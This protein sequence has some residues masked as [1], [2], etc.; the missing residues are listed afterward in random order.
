MEGTP[1]QAILLIR[2]ANTLAAANH[3]R[4]AA[5]FFSTASSVRG[6]SP[7]VQA[8]AL[9][10]SARHLYLYLAA[11]T[12]DQ[13][14]LHEEPDSTRAIQHL[15]KCLLLTRSI[16]DVAKL[17]LSAFALL[18][19]IYTFIEDHNAAHREIKA[20]I[21]HLLS[22][23]ALQ[24][25]LVAHWWA[26]FQCCAIANA[27]ARRISSPTI[28]H[29][30]GD[31]AHECANHGDKAAAVAFNLTQCHIALSSP[32][33]N[34]CDLDPM[35]SDAYTNLQALSRNPNPTI[36]TRADLVYLAL[37]YF[38]MLGCQHLRTGDLAGAH[39][40]AI[41]GLRKF[42]GKLR[43]LQKENHHKSGVWTWLPSPMLSALTCHI[44]IATNPVDEEKRRSNYSLTA[45]GKLGIHPD[46][47]QSFDPSSLRVPGVPP[48][49]PALLATALFEA[50]A[51]IRL[52]S[53]DLGEAAPLISAALKTAFSDQQSRT[54]IKRIES[55]H[56][57]HF[58]NILPPELPVSQVVSR[59]AV[60]LLAA[61]FYSL[62]GK[63][64]SAMISREFLDLVLSSERFK[65]RD[66]NSIVSDTWQIAQSLSSLL[67]GN[68]RPEGIAPDMP[69]GM[70]AIE[71]AQRKGLDTR[72]G[73]RRVLGMAWFAIAVHQMR[74]HDVLDS[75]KALRIVLK[76]VHEPEGDNNQVVA[77]V[78]AIMS[79]LTLNR[80]TIGHETQGMINSAINMSSSIND[81]LTLSRSLRQQ[82]KWLSRISND[83]AENRAAAEAL[84]QQYQ[85]L[86]R[87]Q[88][89]G[90]LLLLAD[91]S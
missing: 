78:W 32:S 73:N 26:Y 12:H 18:E 9:Y 7:R 87:K 15:R 46:A 50:A 79:G 6:I 54:E 5:F 67:S 76:I 81:S 25:R 40:M 66:G 14:R 71:A 72:F 28:M 74:N 88:R 63:L 21:Q 80:G 39:K 29:M 3:H 44:I 75:E 22:L 70:D 36:S 85:E 47:I 27:V 62:R 1:P 20:A 42:Y 61:E 52:T 49:T 31:A 45:L 82:R 69:V 55:G 83:P 68:L 33:P 84:G 24:P 89:D 90:T 19:N 51:R 38:V 58:D 30:A 65:D 77:N 13:L 43:N 4:P 56:A 17:P 91:S 64:S 35:L 48:R 2:Q 37:C 11:A 59:C 23:V 53:V 57:A 16:P 10:S 60:L 86:K 41:K 34:V 8:R